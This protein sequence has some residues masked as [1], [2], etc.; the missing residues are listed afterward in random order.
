MS[1]HDQN[2]DTWLL[3]GVVFFV[4]VCALTL[5]HSIRSSHMLLLHDLSW[6]LKLFLVC[7]PAGS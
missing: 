1:D 6:H 5:Y 2:K 3:A 4:F 7:T